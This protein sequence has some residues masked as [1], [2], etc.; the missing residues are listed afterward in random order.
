MARIE[1]ICGDKLDQYHRN[2]GDQQKSCIKRFFKGDLDFELNA[3]VQ[4][5]AFRISGGVLLFYVDLEPFLLVRRGPCLVEMGPFAVDL[6]DVVDGV[7][8]DGE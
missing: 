1:Y 2:N 4:R 3:L 7:V 8:V 5:G 6:G